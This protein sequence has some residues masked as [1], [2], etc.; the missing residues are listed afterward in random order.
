MTKK[1]SP[2]A[3]PARKAGM[4]K[5]STD[6][7]K[8]NELL[9]RSVDT[10]YP[11]RDALREALGSGRRLTVYVGIDPTADY[12]HLG[13][14]TN[15][16]LLERLHKLGHRI[17]VLV[18][19]FTAMIGDPSDKTAARTALTRKD[20]L[21]NLKTFKAQI[22]KILDFGDKK[23]PIEFKFNHTWLAKLDFGKMAELASHFTVQ[24]MLERDMFERR[25]RENKPLYVHEFFYPLLQ[26]YDSVAMSVDLEIGGTDQTFNML[27]GRTLVRRYQDREKFV[28]TT[29]LLVNPATGEKM[30]SKSLGTG[31][32][33]NEPPEAMFGKA[34]ALPDPGI[35]QTFIDCTRLPLE[36]IRKKEHRLAHG[37][38]PKTVKLELAH[39][40]VAMYHGARAADAAQA[41]WE[42]VF[43]EKKVP[44]A[45]P[46]VRAKTGAKLLDLIVAEGIAESRSAARRLFTEGAIKDL[47][48]DQK[49]TDPNL[50]IAGAMTLKIGKKAFLK[51]DAK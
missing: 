19:D 32:G 44:E 18:G 9:T 47:D 26:G 13:H 29:T 7:E 22:G 27:A 15:Y 1:N 25:L 12:V 40:I 11:S 23:N 41:N 51:V 36:E 37:E 21:R 46:V 16:L 20:V 5:V 38:N 45:M 17:I 50:E 49:I 14:S 8:I 6:K 10:V 24:Q 28:L 35:I 33:L 3:A 2:G 34:M 4:P 43:S 42:G 48:R 30:M 31:I 39:E